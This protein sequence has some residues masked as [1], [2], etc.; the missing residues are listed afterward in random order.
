MEWIN[1]KQVF[2]EMMTHFGFSQLIPLVQELLFAWR[3]HDSVATLFYKPTHVFK[4]FNFTDLLD[5]SKPCVCNS[6]RRQRR[7]LDPRT[8]LETTSGTAPEVHVRTVSCDLLQHRDLRKAVTMGLNHIPLKPTAIGVCISTILDAFSQVASL[9]RL[10]AMDFPLIEAKE[11]VRT[12]CLTRLKKASNDNKFGFRSSQPD[13]FSNTTVLKEVEWI[14]ENLYCAGLDK[15]ANNIC[16]ICIKYVRLL[17]VERLM[18]SD[19][20]PCREK[21]G[22]LS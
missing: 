11:W 12:T 20:S 4:N 14:T 19:F 9:L 17:A 16:F 18:S 8:M 22:W 6:A 5:V 13:L 3:Y 2:Q 15:A 21:N 10:E 1:M 7:F